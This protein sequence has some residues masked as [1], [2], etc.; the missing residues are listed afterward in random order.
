MQLSKVFNARTCSS[1]LSKKEGLSLSNPIEDSEEIRLLLVENA[2]YV[3][4]YWTSNIPVIVKMVRESSNRDKIVDRVNDIYQTLPSLLLDPFP[5]LKRA[6][7]QLLISMSKIFPFVTIRYMR[8]LLIPVIGYSP[9]E[10][11]VKDEHC[12]R[13]DLM[14]CIIH[15][16]HYKTRILALKVVSNLLHCFSAPLSHSINEVDHENSVSTF[17]NLSS[18]IFSNIESSVPFD[19]NISVRME[20]SKLVCDIMDD[21]GLQTPF[22]PLDAPNQFASESIPR[23]IVLMMLSLSDESEDVRNTISSF[24][25]CRCHNPTMMVRPYQEQVLKLLLNNIQSNS[26]LAGKVKFLGATRELIQHLNSTVNIKALDTYWT[27]DSVLR[28]LE[29]LTKCLT[30]EEKDLFSSVREV[31]FALGQSI[32]SSQLVMVEI[33]KAILGESYTEVIHFDTSNILMIS[34]SKQCSIV[35]FILSAMLNGCA[36]NKNENDFRQLLKA[37]TSSKILAFSHEDKD[38]ALSLMNVIQSF[39][40]FD[41]E[42]EDSMTNLLMCIIH[43]LGNGNESNIQSGTLSILRDISARDNSSNLLD[44]YFIKLL[45]RLLIHEKEWVY[46]DRD[47][48]AFDALIRFATKRTVCRYF[49]EVGTKIESYLAAKI[50]KG[51]SKDEIHQT[52]QTKLFFMALL[53]SII[54]NDPSTN[55]QLHPFVQKMIQN[56]LIPNLIWQPGGAMAC[57]TRKLAAA[58]LFSLLQGDVITNFIMCKIASV[59]I[60][61]L[62]TCLR[63]DDPSTREL[64]ALSLAKIFESIGGLLNKDDATHLLNELLH[65]LDDDSKS[66]RIASCDALTHLLRS[67]PAKHYEKSVIDAM[68]GGLLLYLNDPDLEVKDKVMKVLYLA[69]TVDSSTVLNAASKALARCP[70]SECY[71]TLVTHAQQL[72]L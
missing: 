71:R 3:I 24:L 17:Q 66:V 21:V 55:A 5:D 30:S 48:F 50:P 69:T 27:R 29:S 57:A 8:P 1:S 31:S 68:V 54:S 11:T 19:K 32:D 39:C 51:L 25:E 23:L 28:I 22:E 4:D 20:L 52:F 41:I 42:D 47:L 37:L 40:N 34:T 56:A 6:S 70:D 58:T 53:E 14:Q 12:S 7:C 16:R 43:L 59:I 62:K 46:G 72:L 38:T 61:V 2:L 15:H 65:C 49:N 64:V 63:D 36:H 10:M 45:S 13:I 18:Y 35:M 33:T 9:K 44:D 26:S 67:S 60:P